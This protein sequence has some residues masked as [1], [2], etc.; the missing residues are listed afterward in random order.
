[1]KKKLY[2][3][4]I[5]IGFSFSI[6]AAE[7]KNC[8][9]IKKL[10]KAYLSCKSGNLKIGITNTGSKIKNGTINK[11]KNLKKSINN[12]FKKKG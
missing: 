6:N 7:K 1:M 11:T 2:L 5:L 3:I 4:L 9:S 12:P 10:S 8:S